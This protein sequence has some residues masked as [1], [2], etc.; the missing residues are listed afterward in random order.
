[1]NSERLD[2]YPLSSGHLDEDYNVVNHMLVVSLCFVP[3][4]AKGAHI[5]TP[6]IKTFC[7]RFL[8]KYRMNPLRSKLIFIRFMFPSHYWCALET[9]LGQTFCPAREK[10]P[11]FCP[12][13]ELFTFHE[14]SSASVSI[15]PPTLC[16]PTR[17]RGVKQVWGVSIQRHRLYW[18]L[19]STIVFS[20]CACQ[21][22]LLWEMK[23]KIGPL[24]IDTILSGPTLTDLYR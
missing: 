18:P 20:S 7:V 10:R 24:R 1:M 19:W 11:S 14:S 9:K 16:T 21:G 6:R 5:S 3:R 23:I 17:S 15:L 13:V 8:G 2:A 4:T 22:H 12:G